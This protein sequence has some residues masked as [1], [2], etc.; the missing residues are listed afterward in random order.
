VIASEDTDLR[1]ILR[2]ERVLA[3][4]RALALVASA[5][6]ALDAACATELPP[7]A[8]SPAN[9]VV[10][11]DGLG[12]ERIRVLADNHEAVG[13]TPPEQLTDPHGRGPD[14]VYSLAC[15]LYESLAGE[16]PFERRSDVALVFAHLN[17]PPPR[18]TVLRPDLPRAI[19]AVFLKGL[20]RERQDRYRTCAE[21]VAAASDVFSS[22]RRRRVRVALLVLVLAAAVGATRRPTAVRTPTTT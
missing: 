19:D 2:R 11:R 13:Y 12:R 5:A 4:E 3:P 17:D 10:V 21:L 7:P 15:V 9:L 22:A 20:A 14:P 16:R 18:L 6:G 1:E 8:I